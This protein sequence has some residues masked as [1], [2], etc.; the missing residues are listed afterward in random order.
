MKNKEPQKKYTLTLTSEQL[1]IVRL[2]LEEYFRLRMGQTFDFCTDMAGINYDL[3]PENPN[4]KKL[5]DQYLMRRDHLDEVMRT[6]YRIAY[7]HQYYLEKKTDDML[8]AEDI[9]DAIRCHLRIS[10]YQ[11]PLNVSSEPTP[12]IVEVET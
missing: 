2:S 5:F 4:H 1:R 8:I 7:G 12:A 10:R 11:S 9:W 3:S 6:F